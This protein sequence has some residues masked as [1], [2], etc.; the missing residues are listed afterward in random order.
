MKKLDV[1]ILFYFCEKTFD[2]F[3]VNHESTMNIRNNKN[4][5]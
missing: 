3:I 1:F 5:I 4:Y 2:L